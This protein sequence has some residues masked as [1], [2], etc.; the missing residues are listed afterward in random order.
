[1]CFY[2]IPTIG[3]QDFREPGRGMFSDIDEKSV[4]SDEVKAP[5]SLPLYQALSQTYTEREVF[6]VDKIPDE[7][8]GEAEGCLWSMSS[9]AKGQSLLT[10]W[11]T[12]AVVAVVPMSTVI[13]TGTEWL[14]TTDIDFILADGLDSGSKI[15]P[16]IVDLYNARAAYLLG[17]KDL[18]PEVEEESKVEDLVE[19]K[20]DTEVEEES[21]VEDL[22]AERKVDIGVDKAKAVL[23][24]KFDYKALRDSFRLLLARC[25]PYGWKLKPKKTLF[26]FEERVRGNGLV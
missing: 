17:K 13:Q 21:K 24:E 12:G 9:T 8:V 15:T 20:V 14:N 18:V 5:I 2:N 7:L 22:V 3:L 26:G 11:D 25:L 19:K 16:L 4:I 1:M 10:V 6:E 23:T